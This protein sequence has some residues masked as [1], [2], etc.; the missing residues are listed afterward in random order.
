MSIRLLLILA[1]LAITVAPALAGE[2]KWLKSWIVRPYSSDQW[3]V[4][5]R[6]PRV[7]HWAGVPDQIHPSEIADDACL[8]IPSRELAEII[9]RALNE[10]A[11][12][13]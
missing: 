13:R 8:A 11:R 1:T 7:A 3:A 2:P 6:Q 5:R 12:S 9:A 4:S 10:A